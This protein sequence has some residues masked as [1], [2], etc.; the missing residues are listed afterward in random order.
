MTRGPVI[1]SEAP[2]RMSRS[3]Y[4]EPFASR[5]RGRQKRPLGDLFGLTNIGVNLTMLEPGAVSALQHEH[6]KQDE[7]IYVLDGELVV[8][9]GTEEWTMS[10]GWCVGFPAGKGSH[11]LEN[12]SSRPATFLEVGDRT[13][14]DRVSYP[15]DDLVAVLDGRVWR[16]ARKN[17]EG[18]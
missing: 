18:Y 7:F 14:G 5:M 3:N 1:A 6:T 2:L 9:S 4:P 15:F 8:V 11:H 13:P 17:G 10:A 12:R 16:F